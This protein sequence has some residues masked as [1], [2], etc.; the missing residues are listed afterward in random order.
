VRV[1]LARLP[2]QLLSRWGRPRPAIMSGDAGFTAQQLALRVTVLSAC[3]GMSG[4]LI[5]TARTL[6]LASPGTAQEGNSS[7]TTESDPAFV[8]KPAPNGYRSAGAW[9][10]LGVLIFDGI[11]A[12]RMMISTRVA[13]D[14]YRVSPW[15]ASQLSDLCLTKGYDRRNGTTPTKLMGVHCLLV[16]TTPARLDARM[17]GRRFGR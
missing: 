1:A 14:S 4:Q 6:P 9:I 13:G 2:R 3:D 15:C 12:A 16:R 10:G 17:G 11:T 5:Q 7:M 8:S